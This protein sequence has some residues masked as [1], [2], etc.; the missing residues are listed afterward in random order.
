[1]MTQGTE[2]LNFDA[3]GGR[4][5]AGLLLAL[6]STSVAGLGTPAGTPISNQATLDF[7][8]SGTPQ[9]VISNNNALT[10]QELI[11]VSAIWQDA[12]SVVTAS[13]DTNQVLTFL[14]SNTGNGIETVTLS[15][16]NTLPG[17]DNYD[18]LNARIHLDGDGNNAYDGPGIDP[19]YVPGSNDPLLDANGV[20][21]VV[22]FV[23]NDTPA[24]LPDGNTGDS[25]LTVQSTTP[26]AAGAAPGTVLTGL[27]DSGADA[28]VGSS[29]ASDTVT[30]SY[31]VANGSIDVSIAKSAEVVPDGQVCKNAPCDPVP[32]ATIRYTLQ[33][34]VTGSGVAENLAI[35]DSIPAN[36]SY[37]PASITLDATPQTDATGDD[38]GS[39]SANLV[40]V[41]LGDTA[42]PANFIITLDVTVN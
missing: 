31:L 21:S 13:S 27:G 35:T 11:N 8:I 39:F 17:A 28:V 2:S 36:T 7:Q 6:F 5:V 40:T 29:R 3:V 33:V 14:V 32:G 16:N 15:V 38:P 18:P 34:D 42:G 4:L 26:G 19:L 9:Q 20:D 41:D 22:L 37:T 25:A 23:L 24:A 30:G 1:M 12:S 10:V